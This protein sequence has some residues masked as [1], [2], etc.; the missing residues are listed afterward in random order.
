[1]Q[2]HKLK[3]TLLALALGASPLLAEEGGG[4]VIAPLPKEEKEFYEKIARLNTLTTRIEESEKQFMKLVRA[5]AEEKNPKEK[6]HIIKQMNEAAADRNK[7]ADEYMKVKGELAL[8]YPNKGAHL[9]R[10]YQTQN[11]KSMEELE[12]AA[13]LDEML[14]RTKKMVEKKFAPLNE[15]GDGP[16]HA[17]KSNPATSQDDKPKKLRLEK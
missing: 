13:G 17:A 6:Q 11:K 16:V 7:A 5:K 15:E 8:R 14:T 9:N 3:F 12:G 1:M 10:R 2:F 4:K